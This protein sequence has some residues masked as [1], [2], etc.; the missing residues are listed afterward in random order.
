MGLSPA[1]VL[2]EMQTYEVEAVL[3]RIHLKNKESWE[4]TRLLMYTVA[5]VNS[6]K[7]IDIKKLLPFSWDSDRVECNVSEEEEERLKNSIEKYL[8]G[9]RCHLI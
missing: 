6:K 3:K 8:N 1:Y 4:Q 2:D 5:Q 7:K 9:K